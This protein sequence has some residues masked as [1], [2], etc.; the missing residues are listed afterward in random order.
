MASIALCINVYQDAKALRGCLESGSMFFDNIFVIHAGPGGRYSTDGTI[1]VLE[2][3]GI[4]PVFDDIERG[5]GKIRTR[6]IHDCGVLSL[7][8]A[9]S[10]Q[11]N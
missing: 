3:F 7:L 10:Q 8:L 1:E 4:K 11:R 2:D 5:F 6:L 9:V